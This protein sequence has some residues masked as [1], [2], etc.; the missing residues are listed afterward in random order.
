MKHEEKAK[1]IFKAYSGQ[2]K[3]F[4]TSDGHP[5]FEANPAANH[6]K[7]LE[8]KHVETVER[9]E[10]GLLEPAKQKAAAKPVAAQQAKPDAPA[11]PAAP[12]KA[13]TKADP[14]ASPATA[15]EAAAVAQPAVEPDADAANQPAEEPKGD[16][17]VNTSA[18]V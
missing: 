10:L 5:F 8:D 6:A 18:E 11:K 2:D 3:L 7:T 17:A 9:H 4:F 16:D 15:P 14:A 13:K 1:R 12:A